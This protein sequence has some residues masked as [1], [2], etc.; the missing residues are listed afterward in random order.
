MRRDETSQA[1]HIRDTAGVLVS[2]Q[3]PLSHGA[4]SETGPDFPQPAAEIAGG[5]HEDL[6]DDIRRDDGGRQPKDW[7][8]MEA[9]GRR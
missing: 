9:P 4:G 6:W 1:A 3:A 8:E 2:P 7:D 5:A